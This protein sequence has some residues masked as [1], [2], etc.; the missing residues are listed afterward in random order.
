MEQTHVRHLRWR[1]PR[2][3]FDGSRKRISLV[4]IADA[5][6]LMLFPREYHQLSGN[7][8]YSLGNTIKYR[9]ILEKKDSVVENTSK[10]LA[11]KR[12]P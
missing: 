4:S 12:T 10:I 5:R 11:K 3:R 8:C 9:K 7:L 6:K 1:R 2:G